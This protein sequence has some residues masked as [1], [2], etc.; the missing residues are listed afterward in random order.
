MLENKHIYQGIKPSVLMVSE[1]DF[2]SAFESEV[3]LPRMSSHIPREHPQGAAQDEKPGEV[4]HLQANL[5]QSVGDKEY[6]M[7]LRNES[8]TLK[9]DKMHS[10]K[11]SPPVKSKSNVSDDEDCQFDEQAVTAASS[12]AAVLSTDLIIMRS[13]LTL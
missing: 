12:I 2:E 8:P 6:K 13:P 10:V 11:V 3:N 7:E 1:S 5:M 9:K 4:V